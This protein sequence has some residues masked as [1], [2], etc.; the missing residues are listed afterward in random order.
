MATK[1]QQTAEEIALKAKQKKR[2]AQIKW[3]KQN[4]WK[5]AV[6]IVAI[7]GV[8]LFALMYLNT[9]KQLQEL[10]DPGVS[11]RTEL[12]II[13]EQ[14]GRVAE[15]PKDESPKMATVD[16]V[17]ALSKQPFFKNAQNGDRVLI[18]ENSNRALIFRPST[19]KIV[20]FSSIS[21]PTDAQKP[22]AQPAT[23]QATP[24]Q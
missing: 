16:N 15:L 1:N 20:E 21:I 17:S 18:F 23:P 3:L 6:I 2:K 7:A 13:T 14:A 10:Q 24:A 9:K 11:G 8:T 22:V 5:I 19:K 12:Q 4:W